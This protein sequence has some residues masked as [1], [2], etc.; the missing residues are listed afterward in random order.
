MT[1][2]TLLVP[3][4]ERN[5]TSSLSNVI[6]NQKTFWNC[7][8][9]KTKNVDSIGNIKYVQVDGPAKA[10]EPKANVFCD[11]FSSVYVVEKDASF[12]ILPIEEN[13]VI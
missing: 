6:E 10:D 5:T 8:N 2:V 3:Y 12:G 9:S 13:C 1:Y 7:I 11:Y 4:W